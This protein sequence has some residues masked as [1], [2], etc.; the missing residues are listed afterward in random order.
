MR[1]RPIVALTAAALLCPC[2]LQ[3]EVA[4]QNT[5]LRARQVTDSD[6]VKAG[7]LSG[8][9]Y[10]GNRA[11]VF[12][13]AKPAAG[14]GLLSI[15]DKVSGREL[16]TVKPESAPMWRIEM[17][18]SEGKETVAHENAGRACEVV[19]RV[20]DGQG[21]V[22]FKWGGDV[23]VEVETR[24]GP[25][26]SLARSRIK[27]TVSAGPGLKTV[28]FPMVTGIRPVTVN[29]AH[30]R[31]LMPANLGWTKPSPLVSGEGLTGKYPIGITLQMS[32]LLGEGRGLYFCEEDIQANEKTLVWEPDGERKTLGFSISRN[33]LGWGGDEPIREYV[34]PGDAVTGPF[35]GDW[36]DAARIY[37]KWALLAPWC[38]KG[39]IDQRA[40]YPQWLIRVAFWANDALSDE[41]GIEKA[42]IKSTFFDL[43]ASVCHDYYYQFAGYYHHNRNPEY[44]PPRIG[45]EN[46][47]RV[48]R[49]FQKRGIRVIPYV[50]GW[51]WNMSTESYRVEE[52]ERKGTMF[53]A[54][55][56]KYWT[57]AGSLDPQAA[58][59]PATDIWRNKL[60][61]LSRELIGE[62]GVDGVYYD[63]FTVH[64]IDCFVKE[65]GHPIGGGNYWTK[66]VHDLYE[67]I[68]EE[69]RKINPNAIFCGENNAEYVIDVLD[70]AYTG[71]P[72]ANAPAF[73]AV[74]HGYTQT[75][76][77]LSNKYTPPYIGRMWIMGCQNGPTNQEH[78][79]ATAAGAS[80]EKLGPWYR[81]L[82][83]C[84]WEFGWPYLGAGEMLRPPK[85]EGD[86]PTITQ[87]GGYGDFT[88]PSVD[89]TA[90]RAS[91]GSVGIFFLNYDG[92]KKYDFAWSTDLGEFAGIPADRKLRVTRWTPQ[93]EE[94]LGVWQGGRITQ[95]MEIA[96]WGMIALKLEVV[97]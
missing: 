44:L 50:I 49:D 59:C 28:V 33:V 58:M 11:V 63:Y 52:A 46:Y 93:G 8:Y 35:Q 88:L 83:R 27:A 97:Q 70:T 42:L 64:C 81:D 84:R 80:Y 39:P 38:R 34:S 21:I 19:C 86:I 56:E 91:N 9:P 4:A 66:A 41:D 68:R 51:L 48:V 95:T 13:W 67:L 14:G 74:Y 1:W 22:S 43:P 25:D 61:D 26:D 96:P 40:D 5:A 12:V 65:H 87:K 32:A 15:Y 75:F 6:D 29:A 72:Y 77:G 54:K 89:A 3:A 79:L 73:L 57:W 53:G 37:R 18:E 85:I 90:W 82:L 94:D 10:L 31:V 7:M 71:G 55:G 2:A 45:A 17:K 60:L 76:G 16:L 36:F 69:C 23:E 47:K 78:A 62:Y 20:E 30:D 92:E 24:L